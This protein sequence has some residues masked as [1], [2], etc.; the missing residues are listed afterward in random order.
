[1]KGIILA[2][3]TGSRLY[4]ITLSVSKQL[5]P[6]YDKPMVYYPLAVLM[7]AEIKDILI[8]TTPEDQHQFERLLGNGSQWGIS[9][10]YA[11]QPKPEGLPQAFIVGEAFICGEPVCLI[12]GDNIFYGAGLAEWLKESAKLTIGAKIFGYYVNDPKRYGV[13]SLDKGGNVISIEEKPKKPKSNYAIPGIYFFDSNVTKIAQEIL[14]SHRGEL[15]IIDIVKEYHLRG[16]L[17]TK[18]LGRGTAWLDTGTHNSLLD[19]ANFIRV[20]EERQGLKISCL[21]EIAFRSGYID[22]KQLKKLAKLSSGNSYGQYL[23]RII[24]ESEA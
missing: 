5:M 24:K 7:L 14:P 18:L 23:S 15:E 22:I 1:M 6:I 11:V 9:L 13:I 16:E 2:G 4:P 10:Q 12:L 21:E 17:E 19:A 3:G 8:I 20:V